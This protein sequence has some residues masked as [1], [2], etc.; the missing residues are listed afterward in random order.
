MKY[1]ILLFFSAKSVNLLAQQPINDSIKINSLQEITI[2]GS[3]LKT[4]KIAKNGL[5]EMD[6]PQALSILDSKIL[7]QQQVTNITDILK[8]VNGIYIAGNTG[9]Y[10]EEISSRGA[11]IASSNT[12]KNGIRFFS[13]MKIELSGV[14]KVEILK[15]NTAIEYG[16]VAPGGVLNFITK[17]PIFNFGGNIDF[18]MAS[19]CSYKPQV[20]IYGALNK[21]K[22][23]AFRING[24]YQKNN[25]FRKF[26]NSTTQYLNPS[27][28]IKLNKKSSLII[29]GDYTKTNTVPDFGAGIIN[30]IVVNIPRT[31][32]TGVS[33]GKY[34]ATQSYASG[35]YSVSISKQ[36]ELNALVGYRNY[37]TELFTN[38]RPNNTGSIV[39][40]NGNWKR[41]IQKTLV[42]DKYLIQQIDVNTH[43]KTANIK[44]Q[45][46]IGADAE[47]FTTKTTVFNAASNYDQINIY[48]D[49]D[50]TKEPT[51]PTLSENTL[52]K[53]P[54]KRFGLYMQNLI[55]FPKYVKLFIG[56]RYNYIASTSDVYTYAT[57]ANIVTETI[58]KP[59]SPKIGLI[60]Q[61][62]KKH[63]I[64][65]SYSNSFALN[66]GI[67][68]E[69]NALKASIID[70]YEIGIKNKLWKD[71][72]QFNV[73]A[74]Q[75][76]NNNLAQTSLT[77]GNTNTNIKELAGATKAKGVEIDVFVK[78]IKTITVLLGYSFNETKF[79]KSNIFIEGS[80][81][82]YN[83]KNTA[84][85][86]V[87]YFFEKGTFKNVNIGFIGQYF[88]QRLA[89]RS[90]R[91]TVA[92]DVYQLIP[93]TDY[94]L[95]DCMV[96][97]TFKNWRVNGKLANIF[98]RLNYNIHDDN[99]VNPIAPINFSLQVGFTF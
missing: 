91:L 67:D 28:L 80:E 75:I 56:A 38:A 74:Y 29:E 21:Q 68:I 60:L 19:F 85:V 99:S 62:T 93:L 54:V 59:I 1:F 64:F 98:N 5:T 71:K 6:L 48:N 8:N 76:V 86:S 58:T 4:A 37:A 77:N 78:P 90:T 2:T 15:G 88:G 94:F 81:L 20:D 57:K 63:T 43:F 32:F 72:V 40:A 87:N 34:N 97:Y 50:N 96:G 82:K 3:I 42:D 35:K 95:I 83:P 47:Q 26:V 30:Y 55:S 10:Q 9:G 12:F 73:T 27:I 66:T 49:Y 92:N 46:L 44:H 65:A 13:G 25:S 51:I 70:Q 61:P 31:Q 84:N 39:Q 17:K 18:T 79:T 36:W 89:G 24:S 53:N 33:W 23:I 45:L 14:E 11:S 7:K 41:S 16:N 22:T 69:G 52:T